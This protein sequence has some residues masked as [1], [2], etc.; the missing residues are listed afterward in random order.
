MPEEKLVPKVPPHSDEAEQSVLGS[1]MMDAEALEFAAENLQPAD[2]Y[3]QRHAEIFRAAQD[4]YR[5]GREVDLVT[6]QSRLEQ[7]GKLEIAGDIRYLTELATAVPNSAHIR[8]YVKIVK[9]NAR[10]RHFIK[11]GNDIL[12]S[13]YGTSETIEDLSETVESK[14]YEILRAGGDQDFTLL[15]DVMKESFDDIERAIQNGSDVVGIR[16]GFADFD[17]ITAGLS[18]S[19]LILLGA[20]PSMGKT[21]FA[22]NLVLNAAAREKKTCAVFSLEMSKKQ[23]ANRLLAAEARVELMKLRTGQL[24]DDEYMRLQEAAGTLADAQVYIDDTSGITISQIRSKCRKL[25]LEK[26]LDL[27]MIDY[28]QLMS[29]TAGGSDNRV[30]EVAEISRGLKIMARELDVPVIALSQLSRA[31]ESRSDRRPM[32]SDLRESG[33]IEQ[34]AD[35]VCFLYRDVYYHPDTEY[36]DIAELIVAKQRNGE[37]GTVPLKYESL[38]TRFDNLDQASKHAYMS[39]GQ[40]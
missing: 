22:L 3:V 7:T 12:N 20:R 16:T 34:D 27:V 17:K 19:D 30:Q 4:L 5:E 38:Y 28:L 9:D 21:A 23:I 33:S 37:L 6:L 10:Y 32:L 14:V 8:Q 15:I 13:S 29:G 25:K 36:P 24:D 18:N 1:I 11:L 35:I 40:G 31:L 2:F 26:G 39:R